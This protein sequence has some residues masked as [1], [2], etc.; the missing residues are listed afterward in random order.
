MEERTNKKEQNKKCGENEDKG[1]TSFTAL[2]LKG[3]ENC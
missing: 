2:G 1:M 3:T